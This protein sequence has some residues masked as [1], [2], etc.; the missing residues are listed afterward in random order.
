MIFDTHA[1]YDDI[2]FDVDRNELLLSLPSK[3][4][5]GII[6]M[7]VDI[8]T[9]EKSVEISKN[10][11][12]IYS[13]AGIHPQNIPE[14][15]YK[16]ICQLKKLIEDNKEIVAVGEI[17]LDYHFSS[18]DKQKQISLFKNQIKLALEYDFPVSIH[19][20]E[21][22]KDTLKILKKYHPKGVIHCFSGSL[23][24]A[25]EVIKLGMYLGIG[26]VVTFKNARSIVE[27]VQNIPLENLLLETDAPYL[28]P[29][30]FRGK[31]CDSSYIKLV[32]E[33]VAEIRNLSVNE[34]YNQTLENAKNLFNI[35][36]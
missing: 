31:R 14:D 3:D 34:V 17:G 5:A 18:E 16:S 11:S 36:V 24:M 7:G 10:Y 26:G 30:P 9:S 23:E 1:H 32:A 28:A 2:F 15:I 6:N 27:V 33:K 29:V 12:Y 21:A 4:V 8:E 22:H 35:F 20:R 25:K 19:D 13:A